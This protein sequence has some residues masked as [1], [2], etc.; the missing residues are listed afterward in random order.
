MDTINWKNRDNSKKSEKPIKETQTNIKEANAEARKAAEAAKE[1]AE[2]AKENAEA[3]KEMNKA[4]VSN[5]W[6]TTPTA[7]WDNTSILIAAADA[8]RKEAVI[9]VEQDIT[10]ITNAGWLLWRFTSRLWPENDT[11]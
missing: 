6:N 4:Y 9:N 1:K 5:W 8:G 7:I 3:A 11:A 10:M 2:A